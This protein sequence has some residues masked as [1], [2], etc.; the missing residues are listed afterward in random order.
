MSKL[1]MNYIFSYFFVGEEESLLIK[2][3]NNKHFKDDKVDCLIIEQLIED[4]IKSLS[5]DDKEI[6]IIECVHIIL[7]NCLINCLKLI[8]KKYRIDI[9]DI[10]HPKYEKI[11]LDYIIDDYHTNKEKRNLMLD[12]LLRNGLKVKKRHIKRIEKKLIIKNGYFDWL[13]SFVKEIPKKVDEEDEHNKS[14]FLLMGR[15][16]RIDI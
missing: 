16:R 6:L 5:N 8:L 10:F 12:E 13:Y 3:L 15:L 1:V 2:T 11:A 9:N 4:E 7:K 14:L